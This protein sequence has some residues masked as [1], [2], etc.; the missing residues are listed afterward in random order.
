MKQENKWLTIREYAPT[1]AAVNSAKYPAMGLA[2]CLLQAI[3]VWAVVYGMSVSFSLSCHLQWLGIVTLLAC[4][5]VGL[6]FF[7]FK[8]TWIVMI[9]AALFTAGAIGLYSEQLQIQLEQ[10][11]MQAASETIS[12][13][14]ANGQITQVGQMEYMDG[15]LF[16]TAFWFAVLTGFFFYSMRS[17]VG[18][19]ILLLIPVFLGMV[20]GKMPN[21]F[22]GLCFV[23]A[24]AGLRV[25]EEMPEQ[26][27]SWKQN[28]AMFLCGIF[29][30]CVGMAAALGAHARSYG[31]FSENKEIYRQFRS[32]VNEFDMEKVV[33]ELE[34]FSQNYIPAKAGVGG[35]KINRA[36]K[37]RSSG[38]TQLSVTLSQ[39]YEQPF[40]LRAY[41]GSHYT[42]R[43]W[44]NGTTDWSGQYESTLENQW[45]FLSE[46]EHVS[47]GSYG[48]AIIDVVNQGAAD[49]Y[50]YVPYFVS[51]FSLSDVELVSDQY[52]RGTDRFSGKTAL[53]R[54]SVPYDGE[55]FFYAMSQADY[56]DNLF[57]GYESLFKVDYDYLTWV[58]DVDLELPESGFE[59]WTARM[60]EI[61]ARS[62]GSISYSQAL[63][64]VRM[65]LKDYTYSQNAP[66]VPRGQ[67]PIQF[68]LD[69]SKEGYCVYFASA[70][71]ILFRS[72]G[73]PARYV[74]G[75]VVDGLRANEPTAVLDTQAH[76]WVELFR[77]DIGWIP[78]EV[79]VGFYEEELLEAD[80]DSE[81]MPIAVTLEETTAAPEMET[82]PQETESSPAQTETS[83]GES[84]S[85]LETSDTSVMQG[86]KQESGEQTKQKASFSFDFLHKL[87]RLLLIA[88]V[89]CALVKGSVRLIQAHLRRVRILRKQKLN[90]ENQTQRALELFLQI[91]RLCRY[92]GVK[93]DEETQNIQ[94]LIP[95]IRQEEYADVVDCI[96]KAGF[97]KH[98]VSKMEA[99][100]VAKLYGEVEEQVIKR[101]FCAVH[102][103]R[104]VSWLRWKWNWLRYQ[105]F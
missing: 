67:D 91:K 92:A 41:T 94:E 39:D 79:T 89:V 32:K 80:T 63:R 23:V 44:E 43:G 49:N 85:L 48:T 15:I 13:F 36:G 8:R 82:S 57:F 55:H 40:Y 101:G 19:A 75:Y 72:L 7:M 31:W 12:Y 68:F 95:F 98:G 96:L 54:S 87:I 76:A 26:G 60:Q 62:G 16:L 5:G 38:K 35:G 102:A 27:F 58:Y 14:N 4:V 3:G 93:V 42:S 88:A 47:Y 70:A 71:V 28:I 103:N 25:L 100:R 69:E 10:L 78:V 73:I 99:D 21:M 9:L 86:D 22:D 84:E 50:Q 46:F 37:L 59:G 52:I 56:P 45:S 11:V 104:T 61:L 64:E 74:E 83:D 33:Q 81:E 2:A 97:S 30:M 105:W 17:A 77:E 90:Q 24:I 20:I 29:I 34:D 66:A 51:A 65:I 18:A 6:C 53:L 1:P